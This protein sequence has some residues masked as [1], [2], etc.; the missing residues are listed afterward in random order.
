MDVVITQWALD[1]YLDLRGKRVFS[2]QEFSSKI[3]PDVFLLRFYPNHTKFENQK[4]WSLAAFSKHP[5]KEGFK[6]KWHQI[7]TGRVQLRL[8]VGVLDKSYLCEAYVKNNDKVEKR[9]LARFKTH[10]QLLR[11]GRYKLCG[12]LK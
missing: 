8:P 3:R 10:L 12:V 9:Q 2:N 5:L 1:A 6:M 7:G 4:F 11:E